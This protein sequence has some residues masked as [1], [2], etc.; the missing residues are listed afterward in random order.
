VTEKIPLK[1]LDQYFKTAPDED[2]AASI[3]LANPTALG[4][5]VLPFPSQMGFP[6]NM[7]SLILPM[8]NMAGQWGMPYAPNTGWKMKGQWGWSSTMPSM[9]PVG[10]SGPGSVPLLSCHNP[11]ANPSP[12]PGW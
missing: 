12:S 6:P 11:P 5:L 8:G 3:Q 1:G 9:W 10:A 2:K 4:Q 7:M